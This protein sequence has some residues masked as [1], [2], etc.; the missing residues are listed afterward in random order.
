MVHRIPADVDAVDPMPEPTHR[1][2]KPALPTPC[3]Q[4]PQWRFGCS[5]VAH[6]L[7]EPAQP[8]CV[9]DLVGPGVVPE[10]GA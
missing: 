1:T 5:Q 2:R 9:Q 10:M 4:N 3:V 7:N 6:D 8:D